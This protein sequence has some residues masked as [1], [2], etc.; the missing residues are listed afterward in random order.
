MTQ[1]GDKQ[2]GALRCPECGSGWLKGRRGAMLQCQ[3]CDG[4]FRQSQAIKPSVR[5]RTNSGSGQFAAPITVPQYRWDG[6][7]RLA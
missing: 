2:R 7:T 5:Q 1:R 6:S 4:V 3:S